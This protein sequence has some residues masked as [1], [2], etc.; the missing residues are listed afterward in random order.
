MFLNLGTIDIFSR[1]F[2]VGV[3]MAV[4]CIVGCLVETLASTHQIPSAYPT[5]VLSIKNATM[6]CQI[7]LG[8][9]GGKTVTGWKQ[10]I[11]EDIQDDVFRKRSLIYCYLAYV[12]MKTASICMS[13]CLSLNG[14][15]RDIDDV[16]KKRALGIK[17]ER[18]RDIT[19]YGN[20]LSK[21]I[22][23]IRLFCLVIN[24]FYDPKINPC[25]W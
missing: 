18:K 16:L 5:P 2:Y 12:L 9:E 25:I 13:Q 21:L 22:K 11:S 20:N 23:C 3:G 6:H 10:L 19:G 4:L 1:W 8:G 15:D 24:L 14:Q 17:G 7:S